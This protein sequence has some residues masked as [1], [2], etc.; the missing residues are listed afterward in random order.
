MRTISRKLLLLT[1][2][3]SG[4]QVISL[5]YIGLSIFQIALI[6]AVG[7]SLITLFIEKRLK[8]GAYLWFSLIW[9]ISSFLAFILSTNKP[10]ARSYLLLGLFLAIL[11]FVFPNFFSKEDAGVLGKTLIQSQY[12]VFPFSIYSFYKFYFGGGIPNHVSLILG[13]YIELDADILL[14]TQ[15]SS[16]VRLTLPYST[17][18]VLSVVM[19]MCI[20]ILIFDTKIYTQ[21]IRRL[22]LVGYSLVLLL[23]GSRT[24]LAALIIFFLI[25]FLSKFSTKIK[26]KKRLLIWLPVVFLVTIVIFSISIRTEY[27]QKMIQR[28]FS[29]DLLTD[30]HFLVPLDGFLIWIDSLKN[31]FIGI[32]FGSSIN[33]MGKHTYLPP[34]FLNSFI[35]LVAERG[36]M[37][38]VLSSWL[39][40]LGVK[41][42]TN[43]KRFSESQLAINYSL[44]TGL[45]ACIFYEALNC[46]F[47]IYVVIVNLTFQMRSR[48]IL[49]INADREVEIKNMKE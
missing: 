38:L 36:I 18:P 49:S 9:G 11:A 28:F 14:R 27:I 34:Y 17:P 44:L 10:W 4:T 5:P 46:Y 26:I 7:I 48:K 23:A 16:Q 19:A 12:I 40:Y 15:A 29:V 20:V 47:L 35:T 41:G 21:R 2:L 33:I 43:R 42:F 22:L 1:I 8:K 32:G 24:G 30:R 45:L 13:M 6:I 31:F 3:L 37:G 39:I 25:Y